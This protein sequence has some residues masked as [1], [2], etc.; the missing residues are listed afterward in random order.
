MGASLVVGTHNPLV[1][2]I[3]PTYNRE[4][5]LREA[6]ES[7]FRQTYSNWELIVVDDGSTDGTRDYVAT[8]SDRRVTVILHERSGNPSRLRNIGIRSSRGSYVAFLDSDDVWLSNKLEAQ[9]RQ[10]QLNPDCRWSYTGFAMVDERGVEI[11]TK[12]GAPW[13][14]Y[15]GFILPELVTTEA[16]TAIPTVI[17]ERK[18]LDEV[19]G[20][21]EEL[22]SREDYDLCLRMAAVSSVVAVPGKCCLVRDHPGRTTATLKDPY[23]WAVR[24]YEKL[25]RTAVSA[26]IRRLASKQCAH[27]RVRAADDYA[28]SRAEGRALR[29]LGQALPRGALI[30]RWWVV[31]AKVLL[32]PY[33][34]RVRDG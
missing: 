25:E 3:V 19:A 14:P 15:S 23:V 27:H 1:S 21:D 34:R 16:A 4:A 5:L 26:R 7:V 11:P 32:P 20:F 24:V 2:V 18:L 29:S 30:F 8:I 33:F 28:T 22:L 6:V 12:A 13:K 17:A 9:V 31:L 10:M